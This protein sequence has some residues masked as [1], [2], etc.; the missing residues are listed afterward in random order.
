MIEMEVRVDDEVDLAGISINR[1]E[2]GA[3]LFPGLKADTK[4][5]GKSRTEPSSGVG[6]AIGVQP[7]VEQ[8]PAL[9]VLDQKD[10]NRHGDVTFAALHQMN[11]LAGHRAASESIE[12]KWH[13]LRSASK[14]Y[15]AFGQVPN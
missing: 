14:G 5:P 11:E 1:F 6:L 10:G 8:C 4:Q 12:F 7:C 9:R 15:A 2:P 3:D 13:L